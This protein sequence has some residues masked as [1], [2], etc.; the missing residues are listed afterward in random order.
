M[1]YNLIT[2]QDLCKLL[3]YDDYDPKSQPI[4]E[5]VERI[6]YKGG[7]IQ[8]ANEHRIFLTPKIPTVTDNKKTIIV[9]R[10]LKIQSSGKGSNK[11][12]YYKEFV[13]VFDI[14]THVS[15]WVI[16]DSQI[17]VL[18]IA[19]LVNDIYNLKYTDK[20]I[21]NPFALDTPYIQPSDLWCGYRLEY[22]FTDWSGGNSGN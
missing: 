12:V 13:V 11:N 10:L 9:P 15:L 18:Q 16:K 8:E 2:S 17:R 7:D 20:S 21:Q 19:D 14:I 22:R 1:V 6:I 5:N 4:V 3:Y